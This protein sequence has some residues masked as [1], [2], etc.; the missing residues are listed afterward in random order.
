MV[1]HVDEFSC[2]AYRVQIG[3]RSLVYSGDTTLC[4]GLLRLIPNADVVVLEC[5]NAG[6]SVHLAPGGVAAIQRMARPG[7]PIIV[8]HLDGMHHPD[9]YNG[10]IVA[11]DLWRFRL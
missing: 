10:L 6:A 3:G 7:T 1:D 8:T 9:K 5:S 4:E 2:F 11:Q